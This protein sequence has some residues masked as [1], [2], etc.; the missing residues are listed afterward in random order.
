[1]L[2]TQ[3]LAVFTLLVFLFQNTVEIIVI[4]LSV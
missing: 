2:R 1:L 3:S 4:F